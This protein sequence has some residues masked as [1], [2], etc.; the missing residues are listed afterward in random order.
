VQHR[1]EEEDAD[2][3]FGSVAVAQKRIT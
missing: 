3:G 1:V 2:V